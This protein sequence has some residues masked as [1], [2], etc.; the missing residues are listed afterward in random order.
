MRNPDAN[1]PSST[2]LSDASCDASRGKPVPASAYSASES[3]S[4]PRKMPIRLVAPAM[5]K[6]PTVQKISKAAYDA[7]LPPSSA[8]RSVDNSSATASESSSTAENPQ[9]NRSVANAPFTV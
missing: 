2:Y 9:A 8:S 7:G 4:M 1:D 5:I 3:S 6:P